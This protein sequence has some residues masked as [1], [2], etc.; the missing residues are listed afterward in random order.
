LIK[1]AHAAGFWATDLEARVAADPQ[2][3]LQLPERYRSSVSVLAAAVRGIEE[4]AQAAAVQE[5]SGS[6]RELVVRQARFGL[7]FEPLLLQYTHALRQVHANALA[8]DPS[9]L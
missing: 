2:S 3:G 7:A 1:L 4:A 6:Q 5:S 9:R 8:I